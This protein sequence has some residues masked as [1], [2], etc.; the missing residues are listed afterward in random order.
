MTP[1]IFV[2]GS[3][4]LMRRFCNVPGESVK[5][6]LTSCDFSHLRAGVVCLWERSFWISSRSSILKLWRSSGVIMFADIILFVTWSRLKGAN[7]FHR[8]TVTRVPEPS[9]RCSV[10]VR[11]IFK[12]TCGSLETSIISSLQH[13]VYLQLTEYSYKSLLI[14]F[15]THYEF[16]ASVWCV[17]SPP[18]VNG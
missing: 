6:L 16:G 12:K 1:P 9:L 17:I 3:V 11:K 8:K 2:K 18:S 14:F 13:R 5:S 15:N 7:W 4:P 10:S